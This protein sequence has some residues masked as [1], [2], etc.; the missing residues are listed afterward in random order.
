MRSN[1]NVC[2][3]G[4]SRDDCVRC[5]TQAGATGES[6]REEARLTARKNDSEKSTPPKAKH[7]AAREEPRGGKP[8]IRL[9]MLEPTR[10]RLRVGR[11]AIKVNRLGRSAYL[12]S[13][14]EN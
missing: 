13:T 4:G 5:C 3:T 12:R 10:V 11:A 1:G 14:F 7:V 8:R 2:R 6:A 9:T